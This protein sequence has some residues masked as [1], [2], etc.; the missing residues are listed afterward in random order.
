MVMTKNYVNMAFRNHKFSPPAP[1]AQPVVEQ[2][3]N[4]S[5]VEGVEIFT[6]IDVDASTKPPLPSADDYRL[7]A[8]L[9]AGAPL[10]YV[11]PQ[12]FENPE[13]DAAHFVDTNLVDDI[14]ADSEVPDSQVP[15]ETELTDP[16]QVTND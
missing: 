12:I 1:T 14:P 16:Q 8:L 6:R 13:L 3:L 5:I 15:R 11:N 2:S 7:S 10:N 4:S 9:A